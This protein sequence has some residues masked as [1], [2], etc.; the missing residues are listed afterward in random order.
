[1]RLLTTLNLI[2][3]SKPLRMWKAGKDASIPG[4][5]K[6]NVGY[7]SRSFNNLQKESNVRE[8][9]KIGTMRPH[10]PWLMNKG[11]QETSTIRICQGLLYTESHVY[12]F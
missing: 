8:S 3:L 1:M 9:Y 11:E 6:R 10:S 7:D 2:E 4:L 12:V 5:F